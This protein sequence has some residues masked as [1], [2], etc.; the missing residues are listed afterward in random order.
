MKDFLKEYTPIIHAL[1]TWT[2][3]G[4]SIWVIW[5]SDFGE[6]TAA[7]LKREIVEQKDIVTDLKREEKRL[8]DLLDDKESE[9]AK[10]QQESEVWKERILQLQAD[11]RQ[12]TEQLVNESLIKLT[13]D[14]GRWMMG[15]KVRA[16]VASKWKDHLEWMEKIKNW[17]VGDPDPGIVPY[18][19]HLGLIREE[20]RGEWYPERYDLGDCG[21]TL[22]IESSLA[23]GA[24]SNSL[25]TNKWLHCGK[26]FEKKFLNSVTGHN[27]SEIYTLGDLRQELEKTYLG[28]IG[29]ERIV[30]QLSENFQKKMDDYG[31]TDT[32]LLRLSFDID[33]KTDEI[34][35]T[36]EKVLN[37]YRTFEAALTSLKEDLE[38]L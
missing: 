12:V 5:F 15:H 32:M 29:S 38:G 19:W 3:A 28:K 2:I 17:E 11:V 1:A 31:A 35:T 4:I 34:V 14:A 18:I 21:Q 22:N 7:L 33:A 6:Q 16:E 10:Y 20:G 24:M 13:S 27:S 26:E 25:K 37:N 8:Q 36:G 30:S 9:L 23:L